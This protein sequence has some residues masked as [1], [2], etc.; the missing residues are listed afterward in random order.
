M[1]LSAQ[2]RQEL[3]ALSIPSEADTRVMLQNFMEDSG[4]TPAEV[5]ARIGY[6]RSSL[7][8]FL[9]GH[10]NVRVEGN[11]ANTAN[12]RVA[13]KG[14]IDEFTAEAG[15]DLRAGGEIYQDATFKKVRQAFYS[16]VDH[17]H[18]YCVDGAP[19]TRKSFML[20][21]LCREIAAAD[22]HKNG[23]GRRA[24]YVYCKQDVPPC[25]LLRRIAKAAG[26]P[27]RGSISQLL[28][29]LQFFLRGRRCV[30]ALDEAQHL[31]V[32]CI[33][34]VRELFDEPP[35][36]GLIFAGS[37]AVQELFNDLRLEQARQRLSRTIVLPGLTRDDVERIAESEFGRKPP[38]S[39]IDDII[40]ESTVEDF[41]QTFAARRLDKA[42]GRSTYICAR[43]VWF[44]IQRMK[45]LAAAHK[46]GGAA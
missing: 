11:T 42:A 22:A 27:T 13:I 45:E 41:R 43:S 21:R 4:L 12:I 7:A 39:V 1:A 18:A 3:A 46:K 23:H 10:Y 35:H 28:R 40:A 20:K 30:L 8:V 14:L 38:K 19:G 9:S 24:M 5:A 17:G 34:T 26:L 6:S 32:A 36:F 16:A 44:A 15:E 31:N 37:H 2:R 25:E 33:E 29:K